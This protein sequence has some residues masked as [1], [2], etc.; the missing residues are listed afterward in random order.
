MSIGIF[1]SVGTPRLFTMIT[2]QRLELIYFDGQ[3]ASLTNSGSLDSQIALLNA[4]VQAEPGDEYIYD[5]TRRANE[6]CS[7]VESLGIDGIVRM[8]AG[9]EVLLC[10]YATSGVKILFSSNLTVPD[11]QLTDQ[12]H[13][14]PHNRYVDLP[15]DPNRQPPHGIGNIFAEQ[16]GWEWIRSGVW[17][18]GSSS[19]AGS[20]RPERRVK[21]DYCAIASFYSPQL[22]SL[23]GKHHKE[24]RGNGTYHNGWGL[25]RGH[26]LL[27]ISVADVKIMRSWISNLTTPG[28]QKRCSGIDW[29]ALT[30]TITDQHQSRAR[31]IWNLLLGTDPSLSSEKVIRGVHELSHA[32]IYPYLEYPSTVGSNKAVV[33]EETI[34]RCASLYTANL[35]PSS[36]NEFE[37]PIKDSIDIV[38][39][40]ICRWEWDIFEW[41]ENWTSN[42]LDSRVSPLPD[43]LGDAGPTS[44]QLSREIRHYQAN[45]AELLEW[46]GWDLWL[47]CEEECSWKQFCYIPMWPVIYAPGKRQGAIY[48]GV[49]FTEE[50]MREFWTPKC[51]SR[52]DFDKGGGRARDPWHQLPD[53]RYND[54]TTISSSFRTQESF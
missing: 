11:L 15:Q 24:I 26:R 34:L 31:E 54:S 36:L 43:S 33:K 32:V 12:D 41:S 38:M 46:I 49:E 39:N 45:T 53:I 23:S 18:Y 37:T 48:A 22:Q 3:S 4:S 1:G 10:D 20:S 30:E 5:E 6:L 8:N 17:H 19:S 40:R 14:D 9:F 2:T 52:E 50:E 21:L 44:A 47:S 25:R 28:S 13:D 42:L 16:N 51:I 29:Q 7:L 27:D 35:A